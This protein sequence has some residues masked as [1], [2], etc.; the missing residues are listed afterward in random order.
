MRT[1]C[2]NTHTILFNIHMKLNH[3][4]IVKDGM[5]GGVLTTL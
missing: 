3:W 1:I 4:E 5:G 2:T